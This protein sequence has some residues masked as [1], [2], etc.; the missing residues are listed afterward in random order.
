MSSDRQPT[1][2]IAVFCGARPVGN[3]A[4]TA[5]ARDFGTALGRRGLGLVYGAGG[6]GMMG[7]V[8]RAA[9]ANGAAVTGVITRDLRE[10][11]RS[12]QATG[13]IYVVRS[14]HDRK[15]LMYKLSTAFAVLPG[16]F[17]T[18]DELMEVLT[19]NQLGLHRKPVVL[20]NP[21]GYFDPLL[22]LLDHV[23]REGFLTSADRSLVWTARDTRQA[24]DLL[25][26]GV[27]DGEAAQ[28]LADRSV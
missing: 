14:M 4:Y 24:F 3:P 13:E 2:H 9:A 25:L 19:W 11:E 26:P 15:A 10:R 1:P 23:V 16:G 8:A 5:L 7:E 27:Q 28:E 18:L 17:G 6:V 20:F 12:Q 21:N 22:E